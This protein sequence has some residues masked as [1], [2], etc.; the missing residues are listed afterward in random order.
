LKI[1][2]G[3]NAAGV[4]AVTSAFNTFSNKP[5]LLTN[6]KIAIVLFAV[7]VI[8]FSVAYAVVTIF[9]FMTED[10]DEKPIPPSSATYSTQSSAT[11]FFLWVL[12]LTSY[13]SVGTFFGGLFVAFVALLRL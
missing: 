5:A 11:G 2:G 3:G 10:D 13:L 12:A 9:R 4:L 7:G 1:L 6:I 8:S